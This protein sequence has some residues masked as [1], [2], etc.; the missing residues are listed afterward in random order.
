MTTS[1]LKQGDTKMTFTDT[2]TINGVAMTPP[3]L[4]GCTVY[5]L[6]K[7]FDGAT[8]VRN[9]GVINPDGTFSYAVTAG[10]VANAGKFQQEWDLIFPGGAS[11]TFPNNGYNVVNI[12]PELG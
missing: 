9:T 3:Q 4:V 7:T 11:L 2:P 12:L 8:L 1:T 6:M 5:F 10:D